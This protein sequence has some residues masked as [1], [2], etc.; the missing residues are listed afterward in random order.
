[1]PKESAV[2]NFATMERI[3]GICA[4]NRRIKAPSVKMLKTQKQLDGIRKA[5]EI[6]AKV[7]DAVEP[8]IKEGVSTEELDR[9]V[10]ERTKALGGI[11]APFHYEGFPKHVCTSINEV[12]CHGIP[13]PHRILK[14]G[15]I[16][17]VDCTTIYKGYY[18][19]ASRMYCI[20]EVKDDWRR[21]VEVTK[22][23]VEKAVRLAQPW[24]C[25]GDFGHA[26][27]RMARENGFSVV[28]EIG[29]HGCGV[30]FHEDPWVPH[31]GSPNEGQL[32]VPGMSFTIE[33]M[34]NLGTHRV[35]ED[36]E[37]GWTVRTE[38]GQP[39]AQWEY[40]LIITETGN[41]IISR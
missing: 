8:Y 14:N 3:R 20:G 4:R 17:N 30:D 11:C 28:R 31:F 15:D 22:Q 25:F 32:I 39:S 19:D 33:P 36:A 10:A 16:I 7:L 21:L 13:D 6:N 29:G 37:D 41:E 27:D 34:I 18:G 12:V 35:T 24:A 38:D 2:P 1:M 5:G 26:I 23:S 9:I 40:H